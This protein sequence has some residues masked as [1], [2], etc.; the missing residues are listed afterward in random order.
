LIGILIFFF[1]AF[2]P[3]GVVIGFQ[4][5]ECAPNSQKC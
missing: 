1:F 3:K 5:F 2:L 4:N